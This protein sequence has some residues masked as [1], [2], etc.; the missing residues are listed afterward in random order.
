[1]TANVATATTTPA[2]TT[3]AA[4]TAT[5]ATMLRIVHD[6]DA[7]ATVGCETNDRGRDRLWESELVEM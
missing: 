1:M 5:T 3:A 4:A 6:A 7:H 2:T